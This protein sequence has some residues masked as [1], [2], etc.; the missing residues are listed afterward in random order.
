MNY[1]IIY[2][3]FFTNY[4]KEFFSQLKHYI[5][6]ESPDEYDEIVRV[7]ENTINNKI[8]KTHLQNYLKHSY[9]IYNS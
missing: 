6:Q 7:I 4:G 2:S 5:K 1:N 9:R 8:K 3:I